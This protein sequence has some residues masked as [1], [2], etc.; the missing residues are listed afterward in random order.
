MNL[1]SR[2]AVKSGGRPAV[3]VYSHSYLRKH[4]TMHSISSCYFI[5]ETERHK[6]EREQKHPSM[7]LTAVFTAAERKTQHLSCFPPSNTPGTTEVY[8]AV[9]TQLYVMQLDST[10]PTHVNGEKI[11][12]IVLYTGGY[13]KIA[14]SFILQILFKQWK[15]KVAG[16]K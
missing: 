11:L 12:E 7:F 1:C 9:T 14:G 8:M 13:T 16:Q 3:A 4:C 6:N 2:T 5:T 15:H 10:Y